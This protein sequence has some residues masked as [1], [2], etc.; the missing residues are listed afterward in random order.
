MTRRRFEGK[1]VVIIGGNSGIGLASARAF[2]DEGA[3][4][5]VTGRNLNTLAST[6]EEIGENISTFQCDITDVAQIRAMAARVKE[7]FETVEALFVSAGSGAFC[8]ID[9]VSEDDWHSVMDTNLKGIFFLVQSMYEMMS[10]PSS[11]V[12]AGSIAGRL[13]G[14]G[15]PVYAA[16]KAGVRSLAKSFAAGFVE[17]GIRVNVVSPGPTDTPAYGRSLIK[18]GVDINAVLEHDL[19]NIP[20]KRLATPEEVANMVLFLASSESSFTTGSELLVDGGEVCL[21]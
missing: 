21:A 14:A 5:L 19:K 17:L 2:A 10:N 9:L 20:M 13:S 16:S 15:S 18:G 3:N 6:A 4:L 11:I 12:L 8:S 7:E 1:N